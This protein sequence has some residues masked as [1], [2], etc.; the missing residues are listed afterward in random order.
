MKGKRRL[1]DTQNSGGAYGGKHSCRGKASCKGKS[2]CKGKNSCSHT[3]S[4]TAK[5][6]AGSCPTK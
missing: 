2:S 6:A 3:Q 4:K 5:K 1:Y